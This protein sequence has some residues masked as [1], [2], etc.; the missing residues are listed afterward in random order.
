[1]FISMCI[2]I[3]F[4]NFL[5]QFYQQ[6][7]ELYHG[8]H[9]WVWHVGGH[10]SRSLLPEALPRLAQALLHERHGGSDVT[11]PAGVHCEISGRIQLPLG[12]LNQLHPGLLCLPYACFHPVRRYELI[13]CV[14]PIQQ[15]ENVLTRCHDF[16]DVFTE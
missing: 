14:C 13:T 6:N 9:Q 7:P 5:L 4:W 11:D 2:F 15:G 12:P 16:L 10:P 3:N 8:E 1:M